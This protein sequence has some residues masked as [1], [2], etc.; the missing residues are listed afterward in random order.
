MI[1]DAAALEKSAQ[2]VECTDEC[3][4]LQ[5]LE[6]KEEPI[7]G[8]TVERRIVTLMQQNNPKVLR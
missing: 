4:V 1:S 7:Q 3:V 5:H 6:G 8:W 2:L